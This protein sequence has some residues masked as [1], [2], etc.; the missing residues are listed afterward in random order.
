MTI[1]KRPVETE[2][3]T[4][5]SRGSALPT[6]V[7]TDDVTKNTRMISENPVSVLARIQLIAIDISGPTAEIKYAIWSVQ[8]ADFARLYVSNTTPISKISVVPQL[9]IIDLRSVAGF[10]V[11]AGT[12][13]G[14]G[15]ATMGL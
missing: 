15:G 9:S 2:S 6:S 12:A 5:S 8:P 3:L 7:A 11:G 10:G 14:S 4:I 1:P 13:A